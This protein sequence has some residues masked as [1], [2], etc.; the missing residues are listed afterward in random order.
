LNGATGARFRLSRFG[1]NDEGGVARECEELRKAELV[2]MVT[3]I[4]RRFGRIADGIADAKWA[5]KDS[6]LQPTD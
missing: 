6:N 3:A 1:A 2:S 4:R 5:K